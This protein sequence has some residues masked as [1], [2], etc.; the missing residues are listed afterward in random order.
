MIISEAECLPAVAFEALSNCPSVARAI[1]NDVRQ[2]EG[3]GHEVQYRDPPL[4]SLSL[5]LIHCSI[6]NFVGPCGQ[7]RLPYRGY[8]GVGILMLLL[9]H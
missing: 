8:A 9:S 6:Y 4:L 7:S 3:K 5:S 1:A 2:F